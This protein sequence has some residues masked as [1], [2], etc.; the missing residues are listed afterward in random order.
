MTGYLKLA[1]IGAGALAMAACTSF[2]TAERNAA[3]G[4]A[5]GAAAGAAIGNNVGDGD[6]T[7][8]AAI[9]AAVGGVAGAVRGCNQAGDC[10]Q[11]KRPANYDPYNYDTDGDGV[12]DARDRYPN[13]GRSW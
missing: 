4:A 13:D 5:L 6:A 2:G 11:G 3:A 12:V 1:A 8:G 10:G 9:G 7:R